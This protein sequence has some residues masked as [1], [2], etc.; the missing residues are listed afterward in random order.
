[1]LFGVETV[2]S[3]WAQELVKFIIAGEIPLISKRMGRKFLVFSGYQCRLHGENSKLTGR[4][5]VGGKYGKCEGKM[6]TNLQY[7]ILGYGLDRAGSGYVQVAG[8]CECGNEPSVSIKSGQ[9]LD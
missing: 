7:E 2:N 6:K 3:L 4:A 1:L 9:F 8:A 5:R